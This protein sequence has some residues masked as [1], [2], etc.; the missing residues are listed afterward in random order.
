MDET[1]MKEIEELY[2]MPKPSEKKKSI[3]EFETSEGVV[4][5]I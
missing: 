1:Y 2:C 4:D 3:Y 5:N